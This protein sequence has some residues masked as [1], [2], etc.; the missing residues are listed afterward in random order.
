MAPSTG[1]LLL[2]LGRFKMVVFSAVTYAAGAT[3]ALQ[4]DPDLT[5]SAS[6]FLIGYAFVL[7]CQLVAHYSGE[8]FDLASD[9]LNTHSTPLTGGSKA[10][11]GSLTA[12]R[13]LADIAFLCCLL[14]LAAAAAAAATPALAAAAA[15]AAASAAAAAVPA[16]VLVG[17]LIAPRL[18]LACSLGAAACSVLSLLALT[19]GAPLLLSRDAA[20]AA[21]AN[22]AWSCAVLSLGAAMLALAH[23]YSAPPLRLNHNALGE[24]G[25][26]T[27]MNVLLPWFA[28]L[29]Q[30]SASDSDSRPRYASA[31]Y[32]MTRLAPL[33]VPGALF[34][35]S[36]FLVLNMEDRRPDWLAGKFA[37]FLVLNMEDRRPDW[38][39]GKNTLPVV[40][41][42][43]ASAR[44]AGLSIVAGYASAFALYAVG[45]CKLSTLIGMLLDAPDGLKLA[46]TLM[47]E[48]LPYRLARIVLVSLKHAPWVI[49]GVF[50][51]CLVVL[52]VFADG[53]VTIVLASLR[54]AP[55]AV[56][57][58][59]ADCL[60]APWVV[61]GVFADCLAR[62]LWYTG[63]SWSL[64][65]RCLPCL[66]FLLGFMPK[67]N[68]RQPR[69]PFLLG[70]RPKRNKPQL[71]FIFSLRRPCLPWNLRYM[72][73]RNKPQAAA[74]PAPGAP[75]SVAITHKDTVHAVPIFNSN[76]TVQA[77]APRAPNAPNSVVIVG[78]G[79]GGLTL[80]A[81][82]SS[83][84]IGAA[85]VERCGDGDR[86]HGADLALWPGAADMLR[87]LGVGEGTGL[88]EGGTYPVD[89]VYMTRDRSSSSS[90]SGGDSN[91]QEQ[92]LKKVDMAAV[93]MGLGRKF[94][95]VSR[96]RLVA[97]LSAVVPRGALTTA[98]V[99]AV[100]E[101][102]SAAWAEAADGGAIARGRLAEAA[103]GSAIVRD[104][105]AEAADG[106]A[107]ARGRV[108][109]G[110]DGIRSLC[111][112]AVVGEGGDAEIRDGG[113]IEIS[114]DGGEAERSDA[115]TEHG[116][117]FLG[118]VVDLR[119]GQPGS[120]LSDIFEANELNKPN[121]TMGRESLHMLTDTLPS[122][123]AQLFSGTM[124]MSI[125]YGDGIRYSWGYIDATRTTG[126]WFVKQMVSTGDAS[127]HETWPEPLR[128]F[129]AHNPQ[130]IYK[131]S[132][133]DRAPLPRWSTSRVTLIGDACHAVTPNNGQGACMAIEDAFVL[134]V[135]LR[136]YWD[137]PDGHVEAFYQY[138]RARRAHT[139]RIHAESYKQMRIGQLA[140]PL[141]DAVLRLLPVGVMQRKLRAANVFD[142]RPW[143]TAYAE[144]RAKHQ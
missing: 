55:D 86:D 52:G 76:F 106:S 126:Y 90:S 32:A 72:P 123:E 138:E 98:R 4:R 31:T 105:G 38:L 58:N 125:V 92:V 48:P 113:E 3:L 18:C 49:M 128:T 121:R 60:H 39:A 96:E 73:K 117:V 79:I 2:Q 35:F 36:L 142:A 12:Q 107:I 19:G 42:E 83:L 50:A 28:A 103:D 99:A 74:P 118:G 44:L 29:L 141:R 23:Q 54:H 87:A 119:G 37:L 120:A 93:C 78:G 89:T 46:L 57:G 5:F 26:A 144:L 110:A 131:H 112:A 70:F 109:V 81:A 80:A 137:Q 71:G 7:S 17:G 6:T 127:P 140:P 82:L 139:A 40:L 136:R 102:A 114:A 85:V 45:S 91:G 20:A 143:L 9:K 97:A 66:P 41:G 69:L 14:L 11:I 84:G 65:V 47:K 59:F 53:L 30:D 24:L 130:G 111:R 124:R 132:I 100:G 135:L 62:E 43:T 94:C 51:D 56:L 33:V 108:V 101:D 15:A 134:A 133:Q 67:R 77:A 34:K 95:L 8:Y 115:A 1:S 16:A 116:S 27:V 21:G 129:A 13:P 22:T 63:P 88:W 104:C 64:G 25:A 75:D 10:L 61:L 122:D 68:K